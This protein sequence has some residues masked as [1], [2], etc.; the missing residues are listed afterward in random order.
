MS[1]MS[2][3]S[4]QEFRAKPPRR[5][6]WWRWALG[7]VLAL[8]VLAVA[9]TGVVVKLTPGPAPLALPGGV[10][11]ASAG[12][13]DGTWRVTTGS[14]AGFRVRETVIGFSNDVTGRTGD[15]TGTAVLAD[16]QVSGATFQ[17]NL[18]TITVTA[19][20]ASRTRSEPRRGGPSAR[21]GHPHPAGPAAPGVLHRI[22]G[23]PDH[24]GQARR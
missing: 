6:H 20:R 10:S 2:P 9:V 4:G 7:S 15:V 23:H 3:R 8:V 22:H 14:V 16:I 1:H 12:P 24:G 11:V 18:G 5:R 19:R 21:Y 13:L 17:V